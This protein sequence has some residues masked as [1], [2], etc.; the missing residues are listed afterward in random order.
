MSVTFK[1][2]VL[3]FHCT[4]QK[5]A[6]PNTKSDSQV[7]RL[8]SYLNKVQPWHR[9]LPQ[10][11]RSFITGSWG[12]I[13]HLEE[14]SKMPTTAA[15]LDPNLHQKE[16]QVDVIESSGHQTM[17]GAFFTVKGLHKKNLPSRGVIILD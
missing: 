8:K 14:S 10:L 7:P 11:Q 1:Y 5:N 2:V 3:T 15:A 17:G 16:W 6:L 9:A 13:T 12:N 4:S